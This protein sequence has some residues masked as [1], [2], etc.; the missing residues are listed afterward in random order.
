MRNPAVIYL[1]KQARAATLSSYGL[2]LAMGDAIPGRG[3][4][5]ALKGFRFAPIAEEI[6]KNETLHRVFDA[7]DRKPSE[8]GSESSQ[9]SMFQEGVTG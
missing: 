3:G 9:S 5:M 4:Q 7:H 1:V 6:D 8:T 2:K